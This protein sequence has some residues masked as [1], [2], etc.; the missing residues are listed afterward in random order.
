MMLRYAAV[1]QLRRPDWASS[2]AVLDDRTGDIMSPGSA[3]PLNA[4][5]GDAAIPHFE[6]IDDTMLIS[7]RADFDY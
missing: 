2:V 4:A 7:L 3:E 5:L 6:E 1:G